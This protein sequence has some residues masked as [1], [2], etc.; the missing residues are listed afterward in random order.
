MQLTARAKINLALHVTDQRSDGF[1]MLDTLVTFA[2]V[3]DTLSF[4]PATKLSL[5]IDGPE[6]DQLPGDENNLVLRAAETLRRHCGRSDLGATIHL[7]KNLP[8]AS[9]IGGGSADAAAAMMG[10]NQLWDLQLSKAH[11][12]QISL[13]L[14]AD[15]PM[16]ISSVPAQITGIGEVINK[17]PIPPLN[18]VLVNPRAPLSTPDVFRQLETK[19]NSALGELQ[20]YEYRSDRFWINHLLHQRNDLQ[21]AACALEPKVADCL[22][23]LERNP[24]CMIARMSG[25]GAT[26]FG[27]FENPGEAAFAAHRLRHEFKDWWIMPTRT[28]AGQ[29]I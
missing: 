17:L 23:V 16:C 19:K 20:R 25:S 28:I 10:L 22:A 27:I 29:S 3:G 15:I 7:T 11:M 13:P 8:V 24:D 9:G 2:D 6:A 26:C 4:E 21:Q 14:G 18:L 12:M 1:H 5:T